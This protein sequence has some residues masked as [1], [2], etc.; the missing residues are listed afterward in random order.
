[1]ILGAFDVFAGIVFA[2]GDTWMPGW[3]ATFIV[4]FLL[5]KGFTTMIRFP[6]W[7]G[8]VSFFAG[9]VDLV[10]GLT[11]YFTGYAGVLMTMSSVL[12]VFLIMKG[13]FTVVFGL[14]AS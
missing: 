14:V 3:L 12:A 4:V 13:S 5:V 11:M 8:P 9:I 1:M 6:I 2:I 7:F 10:A